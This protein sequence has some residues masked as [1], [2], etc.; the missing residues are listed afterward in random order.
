MSSAGDGKGGVRFRAA[1]LGSPI[2]HSL[3]PVL[4]GAA[5]AALG[6]DD[7]SYTSVEMDE[8]GFPGWLAGLDPGRDA[9]G[10]CWAGLS[11]TMPLKRVVIPL[12]DEVSE[13]AAAVGAVNTV[14]FDRRD[15]GR[16]PHPGRTVSPGG[17]NTV[18]L[19]G[20]NTDVHGIVQALAEV[21]LTS[22]TSAAVL[23]AGA[24]AA[25]ALAALREIGCTE[26]VVY[27]R[28]AVRAQGL[29]EAAG[30]L[31]CRV[32]LAPLAQV[33]Q[34][35]GWQERPDVVVS[36]LP[37]GA[38]DPL[39]GPVLTE[40]V[41]R[42]GPVLLDVVYASWP[43]SLASVWLRAGV[44]VVSGLA[45][46]LHQAVAQVRLMTGREAPVATMREAL[47]GELTRRGQDAH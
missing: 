14:V 39:L 17:E 18:R 41:R 1:V 28:S 20:E 24:T 22:A 16:A 33:G 32:T 21:G 19:R 47:T 35:A 3:S 27:A 6:L 45:M 29:T 9:P 4:H 11:L 25:S 8:A 12:L 34:D 13:L 2:A 10:G 44:P 31:G 46:L 36:T 5:Y 43:T 38:A 7:W 26:P 42:D 15:G 23:G 30:R 40:A 37:A